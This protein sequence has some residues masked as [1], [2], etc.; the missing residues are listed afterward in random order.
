[1]S[2]DDPTTAQCCDP[3]TAEGGE[4]AARDVVRDRLLGAWRLESYTATS[5]GGEVV[6]PLGAR[7]YGLIVYTAGGY[8]SAQLGRGDR[9]PLRSARLEE[10]A[11]E[12]LARA[13]AGYLS[14]G[15]PFEVVGPATVEHHV[16]VSLFPNWIGRS[17]VRQVRFDGPLLT[18]GIASPTRLWGADRTAELVWSRLS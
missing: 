15:G 2:I 4:R 14:Y 8:M 10:A 12:E 11:D 18:L 13:A 6:R 1:M 5:T 17:Q 7:P 9:P 3:T 16:T